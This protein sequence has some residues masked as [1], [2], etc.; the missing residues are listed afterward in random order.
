M[1]LTDGVPPTWRVKLKSG[2]DVL[3]MADSAHVNETHQVFSLML[4]DTT[5]EDRA[6]EF[7]HITNRFPTRPERVIVTVAAFPL[8]DIEEVVAGDWKEVPA[9]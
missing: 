3:V 4:E 2:N 9:E 5:E 6:S 8:G 1:K 7:L